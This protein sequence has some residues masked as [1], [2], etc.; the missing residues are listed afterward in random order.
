MWAV[1]NTV[2]TG[3]PLWMG[4]KLIFATVLLEQIISINSIRNRF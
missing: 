3:S 1:R 2:K 4:T